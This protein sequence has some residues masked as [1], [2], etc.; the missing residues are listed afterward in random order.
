VT[1]WPRQDGCYAAYDDGMWEYL[2][3]FPFDLVASVS[4][5][6]PPEVFASRI[7]PG[8]QAIS[9]GIAAPSQNSLSVTTEDGDGAISYLIEPL[10]GDALRVHSHSHINGGR[11]TTTYHFFPA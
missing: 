9:F 5:L 2:R 6:L 1:L 7:V 4:S 11:F 3:F 8:V 10:P